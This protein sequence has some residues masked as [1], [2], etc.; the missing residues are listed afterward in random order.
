M[1]QLESGWSWAACMLLPSTDGA[2]LG[3][4][5]VDLEFKATW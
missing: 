4:A 5:D 2:A 1:L 3:K